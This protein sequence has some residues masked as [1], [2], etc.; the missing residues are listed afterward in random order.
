MPLERPTH[1]HTLD[2]HLLNELCE[3]A[4]ITFNGAPRHEG[5]WRWTTRNADEGT[6][7]TGR[8]PAE[9]LRRLRRCFGK[10]LFLI[11]DFDRSEMTDPR[12]TR[13]IS[14]WQKKN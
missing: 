11:S 3:N 4:G 10:N 12:P 6:T 13:P 1:L 14:A 7:P 5:N 8:Q 9:I 2:A